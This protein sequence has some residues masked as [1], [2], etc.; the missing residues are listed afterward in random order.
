MQ[1]QTKNDQQAALDCDGIDKTDKKQ[2]ANE[3]LKNS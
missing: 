1:F 2:M 3:A